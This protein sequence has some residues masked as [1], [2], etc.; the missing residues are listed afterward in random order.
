MRR[1][2]MTELGRAAVDHLLHLF[3]VVLVRLP[4]FHGCHACTYQYII[5]VA[6]AVAKDSF[7][8]LSKNT[9]GE[10]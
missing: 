10:S 2:T 4:L 5:Y 6:D 1:H 8:L 3:V 7:T 9:C